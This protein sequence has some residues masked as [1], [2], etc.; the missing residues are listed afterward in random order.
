MAVRQRHDILYKIKAD[1]LQRRLPEP[2][3]RAM[4]LA[5]EKGGSSTLNTIPV[6][7]HGFFFDAK[8][9]FHDHINLRYC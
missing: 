7:E 3:Q 8:A 9:D 5:R 4:A 2:Q 6:A 1:D